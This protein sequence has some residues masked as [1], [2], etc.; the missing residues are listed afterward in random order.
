MQIS[1]ELSSTLWRALN[2]I[3]IVKFTREIPKLISPYQKCKASGGS[4]HLIMYNVVRKLR[5][6]SSEFQRC[7]IPRRNNL[8][9]R[10]T[11]ITQKGGFFRFR[12]S[13]RL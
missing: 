3:A 2:K 9:G 10:F 13:G 11:L 4:V 5:V 7:E 12:C 6:K 1:A 8:R